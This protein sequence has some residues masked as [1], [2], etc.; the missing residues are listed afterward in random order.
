MLASIPGEGRWCRRNLLRRDLGTVAQIDVPIF[1]R[2]SFFVAGTIANRAVW[3][4]TMR[5]WFVAILF[6]ACASETESEVTRE[7]CE[8]Y[9]DHVVE[10]RLRDANP[11]IDVRAHRSAMKRA[12]GDEFVASCQRFSS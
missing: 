8:H 7:R 1:R 12:L 5:G 4:L 2:G 11:D 9:R 6:F 10:L 3:L